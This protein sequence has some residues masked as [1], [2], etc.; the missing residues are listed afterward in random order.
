MYKHLSSHT[1]TL[2]K[3]QCNNNNN[4]EN[5]QNM[6]I[7]NKHYEAPGKKGFSVFSC[8]LNEATDVDRGRKSET[9]AMVTASP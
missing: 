8:D 7:T 6:F 3:S 5:I 4:R 1:M 9:V 2:Y